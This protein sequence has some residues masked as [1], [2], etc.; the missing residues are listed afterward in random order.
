MFVWLKFTPRDRVA[1]IEPWRKTLERTARRTLLLGHSVDSC[2]IVCVVNLSAP[3]PPPPSPKWKLTSPCCKMVKDY[4]QWWRKQRQ[5]NWVSGLV[6]CWLGS[7]KVLEKYKQ[8][9]ICSLCLAPLA[10]SSSFN[11]Q[12]RIICSKHFSQPVI[13]KRALVHAFD[14]L[15]CFTPPI[16]LLL[17]EAS[18][19]SSG[20]RD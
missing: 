16:Y 9:L 13:P 6:Y 20:I 19:V 14:C 7:I 8:R 2:Y 4:T 17:S 1:P 18:V 5:T 10:V 15:C 11:P 3:H 12:R